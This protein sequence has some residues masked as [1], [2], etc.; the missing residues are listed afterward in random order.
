MVTYYVDPDATGIADGSSWT[1]AYTSLQDAL[2][3]VS[4]GDTIYCRGSETSNSSITSS[5]DATPL[6]PIYIIGMNASGVED[7]TRY[8]IDANDTAD[9][10]FKHDGNSYIIRNLNCINGVTYGI[11][12]NVDGFN[13]VFVN[14][15][16]AG[17]GGAGLAGGSG[18]R[19]HI[20]YKCVA[21]NNGIDGLQLYSFS[22]NSCA[23]GCIARNN[24]RDG[25]RSLRGSSILF[26][27]CYGNTSNGIVGQAGGAIVG[28][29]CEDNGSVGINASAG[30]GNCLAFNRVTN[31]VTD[32]AGTANLVLTVGNAFFNNTNT[33]GDN[34]LDYQ[35]VDLTTEGYENKA[36]ENFTLNRKTGEGIS[37]GL[38]IDDKN[39]YYGTAGLS[40]DSIN[41]PSITDIA[42]SSGNNTSQITITGTN[43]SASGNTVDIGTETGITPDSESTTEI[44]F[45]LSGTLSNGQY[46]IKV[47]T[48][49]AQ[50]VIAPNGF[51]VSADEIN[52]TSITPTPIKINDVITVTGTNFTDTQG[53]GNVIVG[54]RKIKTSSWSDTEIIGQVQYGTDTGSC[55][56]IVF[57]GN[58]D[59]GT[60]S[61]VVE[62]DGI[63]FNEKYY[64]DTIIDI[65]NAELE[66]PLSS[67]RAGSFVWG[68]TDRII[69]NKYL[70]KIQVAYDTTSSEKTTYGP[71]YF[72]RK[73]QPFNIV[74][75]VGQ[76]SVMGGSLKNEDIVYHF[77]NQIEGAL[78]N[79]T[80]NSLKQ[81][82]LLDPEPPVWNNDKT[83]LVGVYPLYVLWG[84]K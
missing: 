35:N 59:C 49:D 78:K 63:Q 9:A 2:D 25:I 79:R 19:D 50:E 72:S 48:S 10:A 82:T 17:S 14:C 47:T 55:P 23:V 27:L 26:N 13:S 70:P 67:N 56:A 75:Y 38:N 71:N 65:L 74:V 37:I 64:K 29:T 43:F 52:I 40:P 46:D 8:T 58:L 73:Q 66:D 21:E 12:S 5:A 83:V 80:G 4:A 45:T 7:G 51:T 57:T 24:G 31:N 28:N 18:S 39:V 84:K 62:G 54:G 3:V 68:P 32:L 76:D 42:P 77:Y 30:N 15:R 60:Y 61:V 22:G 34:F 20:W 69:L 36:G 41:E 33:R 53:C 16:A 81:V 44:V 1:D 6:D 11:Q